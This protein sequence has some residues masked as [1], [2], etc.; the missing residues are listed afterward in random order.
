MVYVDGF[1]LCLSAA[2]EMP[3]PPSPDEE[4]SL[5]VT[6]RHTGPVTLGLDSAAPPQP[7]H[8]SRRAIVQRGDGGLQVPVASGS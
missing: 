6:S 2:L 8:H 1:L 7:S 4:A 5:E 3:S